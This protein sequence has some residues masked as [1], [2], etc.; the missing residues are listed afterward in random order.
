MKKKRKEEFYSKIREKLDEIESLDELN[1]E[2]KY[3][4]QQILRQVSDTKEVF[5]CI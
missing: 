4:R 3:L 5:S 2:Q 1:M